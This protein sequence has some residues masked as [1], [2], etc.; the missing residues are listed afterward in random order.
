MKAKTVLTPLKAIR[1]H[2][3]ECV[4]NCREDVRTCTGTDCPLWPYRFGANP[5]RKDKPL[6]EAEK[7]VR[8]QRLVRKA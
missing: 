3:L 5:Y 6:T 4:G 2:C 8:T 7:K 1:Q